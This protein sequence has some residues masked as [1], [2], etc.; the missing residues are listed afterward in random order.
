MHCTW[1]I[2]TVMCFLEFYIWS[3][4]LNVLNCKC[5]IANIFTYDMQVS[6]E[7]KSLKRVCIFL[8]HTQ[9][10]AEIALYNTVQLLNTLYSFCK[11]WD[12]NY[13]HFLSTIFY[14]CIFL[15]I[16]DI[17]HVKCF[18]YLLLVLFVD[19]PWDEELR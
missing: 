18:C 7:L 3:Q 2:L 8:P 12:N 10:R 16:Y 1:F 15:F 11:W 6:R 4:F 17:F 19:A 13:S 9:T 14:L 5:V